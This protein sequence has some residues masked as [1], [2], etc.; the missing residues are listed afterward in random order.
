MAPQ[1]GDVENGDVEKELRREA[2]PDAAEMGEYGNLVRYISTYKDGRRGST[3]SSIVDDEEPKKK[4]WQRKSKGGVTGQFD[5]P[6]EWLNTDM[7]QGLST[8]DVESR[9]KK[10]GWNELTTEHT[11]L[12]I[13]FLGY[14][15]G[16]ILY[17][18][19]LALLLASA[20]IDRVTSYGTCCP[21]RCRSA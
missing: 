17:G 7:R 5:T 9:R 2:Q 20:S 8:H 6:D 10:T 11:N 12:F 21:P 13:Q 15:Q 19:S 18:K 14:F 4:W 16:P 3:V 1:N